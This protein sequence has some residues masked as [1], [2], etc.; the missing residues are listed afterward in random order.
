MLIPNILKYNHQG[1]YGFISCRDFPNSENVFGHP[2]ATRGTPNFRKIVLVPG[3]NRVLLN[4]TQVWLPDMQQDQRVDTVTEIRSDCSLLKNQNLRD[5]YR[6]E[7]KVCFLW[8][9]NK[10]YV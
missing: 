2:R 9:E 1:K 3:W 6:L 4:Q 7:K 8:G 10:T 5:E